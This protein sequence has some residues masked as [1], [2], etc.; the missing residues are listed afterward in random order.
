MEVDYPGCRRKGPADADGFLEQLPTPSVLGHFSMTGLR[1][2]MHLFPG[3]HPRDRPVVDVPSAQDAGPMQRANAV[4]PTGAA[5]R[6]RPLAYPDRLN[7]L[8]NVELCG[9]QE[10][11]MSR[12]VSIA[13]ALAFV[14]FPAF[15]QSLSTAVLDEIHALPKPKQQTD[16]DTT[17]IVSIRRE[18]APS[19]EERRGGLWQSW[20]VAVCNGCGVG[21]QR[22][23]AEINAAADSYSRAGDRASLDRS[24]LLDMNETSGRASNPVPRLAVIRFTELSTEEAAQIRPS[25]SRGGP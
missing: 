4:H 1:T 15:A 21:N 13:L 5:A 8:K 3:A 23:V 17:R 18:M 6:L 19:A 7:L 11:I 22:T 20:I 2:E 16:L 14:S 10:F 24:K 25:H 9:G 12:P